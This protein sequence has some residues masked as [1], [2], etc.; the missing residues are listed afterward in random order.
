MENF[1]PIYEPILDDSEKAVLKTYAPAAFDD[2]LSELRVIG[3]W[4]SE[5][6][7]VHELYKNGYWPVA[8]LIHE[9][10]SYNL[11]KEVEELRY[12]LGRFVEQSKTTGDDAEMN[13]R[14]ALVSMRQL[15]KLRHERLENFCNVIPGV[16]SAIRNGDLVVRHGSPPYLPVED[17]GRFGWKAWLESKK[18][19]PVEFH[20]R[21]P[22]AR[23]VVKISEIADWL[24][25]AGGAIPDRYKAFQKAEVEI[26]EIERGNPKKERRHFKRKRL[27]EIDNLIKAFDHLG[28]SA[29]NTPVKRSKPMVRKL[30][31]REEGRQFLEQRFAGESSFNNLWTDARALGYIVG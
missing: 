12:A 17:T 18:D 29:K 21:Y 24:S 4:N 16:K 3:L 20:D 10:A 19:Y 26:S 5:I 2:L 7:E 23:L 15:H 30:V 1:K 25:K 6:D 27:E 11:E 22:D 28:I 31:M 9:L 14:S 13:G 8:L